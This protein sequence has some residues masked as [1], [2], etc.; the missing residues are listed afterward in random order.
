MSQGRRG[1]INAGH[2]P[3]FCAKNIEQI[4][5]HATNIAE[6]VDISWRAFRSKGSDPRATRQASG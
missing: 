6:T 2:H 4:G 3:R 5:D 1:E